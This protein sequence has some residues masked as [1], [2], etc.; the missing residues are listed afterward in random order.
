MERIGEIIALSGADETAHQIEA[1]A[2]VDR[3]SRS[4]FT[5]VIENGRSRTTRQHWT[6]KWPIRPMSDEQAQLAVWGLLKAGHDVCVNGIWLHADWFR[7]L[8]LNTPLV[9][10][11]REYVALCDQDEMLLEIIDSQPKS[12]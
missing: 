5:F 1:A 2:G 10:A 8:L 4:G 6:V 7:Q 9:K 3:V 12:H 11:M